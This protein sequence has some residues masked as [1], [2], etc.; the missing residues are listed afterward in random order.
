MGFYENGRVDSV[1]DAFNV[2]FSIRK[3]SNVFC[4]LS[5]LACF[6]AVFS[7]NRCPVFVCVC[8]CERVCSGVCVSSV[9]AAM[10]QPPM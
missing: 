3:I 4:Y 8:A 2:L 5:L 1:E 10:V 7:D 6:P 9:T